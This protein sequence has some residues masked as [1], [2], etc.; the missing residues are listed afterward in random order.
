[1]NHINKIQRCR[2]CLDPDSNKPTVNGKKRESWGNLNLWYQFSGMVPKVLTSWCSHPLTLKQAGMDDQ[3]N[4]AEVCVATYEAESFLKRIAASSLA[5]WFTCSG[6]PRHRFWSHSGCPVESPHREDR[7]RLPTASTNL[8][9]SVNEPA[10]KQIL[11]H[12]LSFQVTAMS[13][14][15]EPEPPS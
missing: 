2:P 9:V 10:G 6:G 5:P 13:G 11:Q 12:L 8:P 15:E 14:D 4:T 1:M 3:R 7:S